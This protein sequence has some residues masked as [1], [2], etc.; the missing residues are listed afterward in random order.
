MEKMNGD[1]SANFSSGIFS[2]DIEFAKAG[3]EHR[4]GHP[5]NS[6]SRRILIVED[7]EHINAILHDGL[8]VEGRVLLHPV[9][10]GSEGILNLAEREYHLIVLDLMLPGLSGEAFMQ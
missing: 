5:L 8:T 2:I 10:S 6:N 4:H 7:D 1:A 9:Y 3:K